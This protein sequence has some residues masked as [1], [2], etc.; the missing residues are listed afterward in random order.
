MRM[1]D[2][3]HIRTNRER[4]QGFLSG[5]S[6][7]RGCGIVV[8][9]VDKKTQKEGAEQHQHQNQHQNDQV[10][11]GGGKEGKD[12]TKTN[13]LSF[14]LLNFFRLVQF[15]YFSL[16]LFARTSITINKQTIY[17]P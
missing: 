2:S 8:L 15:F 10:N 3:I 12:R 9:S 7:H 1:S 11:D 13:R 5:M 17:C 4:H 14:K 16:Y 6:K